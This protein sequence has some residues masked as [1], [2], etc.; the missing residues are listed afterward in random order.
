M[1]DRN[2]R[3]YMAEL[4][5]TFALVFVSAGATIAA[6]MMQGGQVPVLFSVGLAV[7]LIYA[8]VLAV[9]MP[10]SG[11]YLNPAFTL[12]LWVFKRLDGARA[13]A[14]ILVQM[15]GGVI[16]GLAL[17]YLLP[18]KDDLLSVTRLGTPHLN[19]IYFDVSSATLTPILKGIGVELVLTFVVAF[20]LCGL[21]FDPRVPRGATRLSALWLGLALGAMT[22]VGLPLTGAAINPARWFG[23]AMA[24][25]T[26]AFLRDSH[27]FADHALFWIGPIAGALAAGWLYTALVL[28]S[29]EEQQT[30]MHVPATAGSATAGG[31]STYIRAKK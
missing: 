11:G 14:L 30:G 5:G 20:V 8:A 3:A 26:V 15:L 10:I 13:F 6:R 2:L 27:P 21:V 29:E 24:E 22:M 16:G 9:T 19:P 28:P 4:I 23:P 31:S 17:R 18:A 1:D 12:M 7:A 25:M